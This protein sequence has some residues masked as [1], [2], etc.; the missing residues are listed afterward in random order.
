MVFINISVVCSTDHHAMLCSYSSHHIGNML[1]RNSLKVVV[2]CVAC[3]CV[4]VCVC[5]RVY[6]ILS[7]LLFIIGYSYKFLHI[8]SISFTWALDYL[9]TA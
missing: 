8:R 5:V 6:I 2:L 4:C 1:W 7:L 3:V 9:H